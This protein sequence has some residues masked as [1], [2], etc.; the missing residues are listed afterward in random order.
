MNFSAHLLKGF[1]IFRCS[2]ESVSLKFPTFFLEKSS[3]NT[4]KKFS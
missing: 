4:F 2:T 1:K 3:I